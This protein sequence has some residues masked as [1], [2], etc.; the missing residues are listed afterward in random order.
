M[1]RPANEQ[2]ARMTLAAAKRAKAKLGTAWDTLPHLR[3]PYTAIEL[4][5]LM[6]AKDPDDATVTTAQ[7]LIAAADMFT[8]Q[9]D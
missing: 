4:L 7:I 6:A 2:A 9:V 8:Q 1:T 5:A 3:D